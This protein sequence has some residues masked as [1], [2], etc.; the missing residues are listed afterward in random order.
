MLVAENGYLGKDDLGRQYYALAVHGHNGSGWYPMTGND[1]FGKLGITLQPWVD[2]PDGY[3]LVCGQRGI[4]SR[5]MA[6]PENWHTSALKRVPGRGKVRPHPGKDAAKA[7]ALTS[8][9][10]DLA[11]AKR[12]IVWSSSSGVKALVA[13]IPVRYDAPF[14]IC[15]A[16]ATRLGEAEDR[17]DDGARLYAMQCMAHAQHSI[18]ELESGEPFAAIRDNVEGATW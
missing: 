8:L 6:S 15:S 2:R 12:C 14:W 7:P 16:G 5:T 11:G 9:D 10:N 18:A 17:R 3:D 13:G 1:R 4:G